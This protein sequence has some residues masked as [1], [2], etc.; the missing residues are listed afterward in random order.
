MASWDERYRDAEWTPPDEPAAF[1]LEVLPRLPPGRVLDVA[2]GA[3]RNAIHLAA[4][5]WDVDAVDASAP[6][7][8][9]A[10]RR[11][12]ERGVAI[13]TIVADL[14]RWRPPDGAYDVVLDFEYL[15]RPRL[16]ALERAL[17]PGG[18][19][20]FET[21]T[22][23]ATA[24]PRR[25]EF[26]LE[27]G[28]LRAAF[29][30]LAVAIYEEAETARLLALKP[31]GATMPAHL[32]RVILQVASVEAAAA[33]WSAILRV[34]GRR[35]SPGRHYF[36]CGGTILACFDPRADGDD[37]D[38]RPNPDHVYLAVDDL[39]ATLERALAAGLTL[40]EQGIA[41]RPWGERSFYGNDPWGNP[42]CFVDGKTKFVG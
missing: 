20:V 25:R 1:L 34:P 18:A 17:R 33:F 13:A 16:G 29:P 36:D 2:A 9:I 35:V 26:R 12:S 40:S 38:A 32:F 11:A 31:R 8:E 21:F 42:I 15:D 22:T 24:G 28:E 7:L 14:E 5:G 23:R 30:G 27:P 19:L 10:R 39:E 3:G 4:L 41:R 37:F 6:G